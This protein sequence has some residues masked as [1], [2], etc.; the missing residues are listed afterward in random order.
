MVVL[1]KSNVLDALELADAL[2][3]NGTDV[4]ARVKW[5][6]DV[7]KLPRDPLRASM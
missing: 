2:R 6:V 7:E 4:V 1:A 5:F 3:A